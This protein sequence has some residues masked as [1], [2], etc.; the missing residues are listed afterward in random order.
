MGSI[1]A[2]SMTFFSGGLMIIALLSSAGTPNI[3]YSMSLADFFPAKLPQQNR[4][5]FQVIRSPIS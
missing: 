3:L 2:A 5:E 1:A 4:E